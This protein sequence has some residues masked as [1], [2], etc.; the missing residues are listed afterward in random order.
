MNRIGE[1]S[2]REELASN[3][4]TL[5]QAA[6]YDL[7]AQICLHENIKLIHSGGNSIPLTTNISGQNIT[8]ESFLF[9]LGLAGSHAPV[10][11]KRNANRF[12]T[13][14]HLKEVF[15]ITQSYCSKTRQLPL[16]EIES[17]YHF[18]R[19]LVN[20]LSHDF[21]LKF[22]KN[23]LKLLPLIYNGYE[24]TNEMEGTIF[25]LPLEILLRLCDDVIEFVN[26][27]IE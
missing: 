26:R 12:L 1:I 2:N 17:W 7:F 9:S 23:D 14:N 4:F 5:R 6:I 16:M 15:R 8:I 27:R 3:L 25:S 20:D 11:T 24:I 22:S 10:E 21:R 19:I 18:S 13:R